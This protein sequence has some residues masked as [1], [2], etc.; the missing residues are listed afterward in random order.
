MGV[1]HAAP[2]DVGDTK[3]GHDLGRYH[4]SFLLAVTLLLSL[5]LALVGCGSSSASVPPSVGGPYSAF[6]TKYGQPSSIRANGRA[7]FR[8]SSAP[9]ILLSVS[10]SR[11]TVQYVGADGPA[12][13]TSQDAFAFCARFLPKGATEYRSDGQHKYYHSGIGELHLDVPSTGAGTSPTGRGTCGL[14]IANIA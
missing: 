11:G 9:P 6:V 3:G 5:L 2:A 1:G 14:T 7:L 10:P 8:A 12:T 13:W 4:V